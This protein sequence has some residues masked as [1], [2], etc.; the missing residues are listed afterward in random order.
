MKNNRLT[1]LLISLMIATTATV[2]LAQ[3][4]KSI[5]VIVNTSGSSWPDE[6]FAERLNTLI[7]EQNGIELA[8]P[9]DSE[10]LKKASNGMFNKQ[11]AID[12]G[13]AGEHRF[14]LWCDVRREEMRIEKGFA[15]PFLAKQRRVTAHMEVEYRIVDCQRGRL[16]VS[17]KLKVK[18]HGPSSMQYLDYTDADPSLYLSYAERKEMFD[19]LERDAADKLTEVIDKLARQR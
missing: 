4:D 7:A 16:V 9:E 1:G 18:E 5:I 6:G 11:Q 8:E 17:D 2:C 19:K 12:H 10:G 13:V 3:A 14:V 15:L